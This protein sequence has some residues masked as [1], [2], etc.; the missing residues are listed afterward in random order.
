MV[1]WPYNFLIIG[2]V[3][4]WIRKRLNLVLISIMGRKKSLKSRQTLQTLKGKIAKSTLLSP[5]SLFRD[6][7][8]NDINR[9]HLKSINC[10]NLTKAVKI[11]VLTFHWACRVNLTSQWHNLT[12]TIFCPTVKL[13][14]QN[15]RGNNT[16]LFFIHNI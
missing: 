3:I 16:T 10:L 15:E 4:F 6:P 8:S 11:C 7:L 14:P 13:T 1:T 2:H 9:T 5:D 12:K